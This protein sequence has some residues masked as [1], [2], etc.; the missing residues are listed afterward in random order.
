IMPS[1]SNRVIA[2]FRSVFKTVAA[3][4]F[5]TCALRPAGDV[6]CWG[7]NVEG[8]LGTGVFTGTPLP[9]GPVTG[10]TNAIAIAAG[11]YHTCALLLGGT[12]LCW[13]RNMEGQVGTATFGAS[14]ATPTVVAKITGA[15]AVTAGGYHTCAIKAGGSASCWGSNGNYQLGFVTP[16]DFS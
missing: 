16:F 13:G 15:V 6:V 7:R 4:A 8:Q 3:G 2:Y 14:V 12:V 9:P 11:G 1:R 10:I 5:H